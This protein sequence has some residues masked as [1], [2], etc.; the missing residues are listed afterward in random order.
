MLRLVTDNRDWFGFL[1][2]GENVCVPAES[3]KMSE[4]AVRS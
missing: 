3:C 1:V 4:L 2:C